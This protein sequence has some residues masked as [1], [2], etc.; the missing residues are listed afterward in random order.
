MLT[1]LIG[2]VIVAQFVPGSS[3]IPRRPVIVAQ[4]A[5]D[6]EVLGAIGA[7]DANLIE[8][9][10]LAS[11]KASSAE[12]KSFA[13][14]VLQSHRRSL[15][16]GAELAKQFNLSRELPPDSVMARTQSQKMDE[17]SLLSGAAFDR[18][19]MQYIMDTHEA[20][21]VK[22]SQEH[23]P[24]SDHPEVKAFATERLPSLRAHQTTAST[25]LAAN[26]P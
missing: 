12:V 19:Y 3:L 2:A 1:A 17:M 9:S 18:V 24:G 10:T 26:R 23:V 6:A 15:T 22:A 13:A 5:G 7:R 21:L 14:E 4:V 16:R 25:W 20:E 11:T 8:A